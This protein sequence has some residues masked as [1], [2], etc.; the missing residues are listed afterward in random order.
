MVGLLNCFPC[1]DWQYEHVASFVADLPKEH[2]PSNQSFAQRY[3][4]A[5]SVR[6][7]LLNFTKD[8]VVILRAL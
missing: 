6:S 7:F 4:M 5:T 1:S 2:R 8:K 3:D